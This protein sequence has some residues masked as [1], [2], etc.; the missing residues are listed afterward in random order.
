MLLRHFGL[1]L[2]NRRFDV[3]NPRLLAISGSL[4]GTLWAA[5]GGPLFMGR[6]PSNQVRADATDAAVSRR[7]CSVIEVS[8]GVFEIADLD[9]HNGTF[10][11]G[12]KVSRKAI[13]HGDRIRIG[14]SEYLF[15]TRPEDADELVSDDRIRVTSS[16]LRI[17]P[18]DRLGQPS[19][20]SG[21]GRMARDLSAFFRIANI[22]NSTR[23][24]QNLQL[25]LLVLISEVIPAAQGA[26]VLQSNN[27]EPGAPC[28]WNRKGLPQREMLIRQ[29]LVQQA[30]WERC[31]TFTAAPVDS[32]S[33]EHVLCVP[34]VAVEKILGV[35]YLSSPAAFAEEHAYFLSSV[36]RIA[37]VTL[38][39]L[40][41]LDLL[42]AENDR[43]RVRAQA[44]ETLIGESRPMLRVLEFIARVAKGDSTVLIRGESGTGK[45]LVARSIHSRSLRRDKPFIA[46]NCA[47]IPEALLESELFGHEKGAFTG[48]VAIRKGKLEA[49]GDG[50]LFLD[51]IAEMAPPLQAKL[52]RVLQ[53][54]EFER[55]GGNRLLPF[56]ARVVAATNKNLEQAIKAGEFRQDLYYR[57][58]VV[59]VGL[60]P[61]REHREDIPLLALHFSNKYAVKCKR[62]F[63]GITAEARTLL[64]QYSWPGNVRELENAIEHAIVMGLTD[65]ILPED[66]PEALLEEQSAG[67][68]TAR[69]HNALNQTKKQLVLT[70]LDE[71]AGSP[72]D[73]ARLLGIHPKY[74]HRLIRNLHLKS[75][76]KRP[77]KP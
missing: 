6:D 16:G 40:S 45:E 54:R 17:L 1:K 38:E 64:M 13:E 20:S 62:G 65:E 19:D 69:Y 3:S 23:D 44:D 8:S 41:R 46:I 9:S 15:L 7:H 10:V 52:L 51:E 77:G 76:A 14:K 48:A 2:N 28:T 35:I 47:A 61:L 50:T 39:N 21:V 32:A 25:E 5:T 31:A 24:L 34:L 53:Q 68:A 42:R 29:E 72:A 58:N 27:D 74:L 33:T 57:L 60:P 66:L 36:S 73:A 71:A 11:N 49:A 26:I 63:K 67:L 59:S 70:A 56:E 75:D 43:L 30:I 18:L 22:I 37:A 12:S 4:K 55:L